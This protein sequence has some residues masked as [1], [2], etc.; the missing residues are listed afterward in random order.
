MPRRSSRGVL[1]PASDSGPDPC[2][3]LPRTAFHKLFDSS[4]PPFPH[5]GI[6]NST[7]LKGSCENVIEKGCIY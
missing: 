6:K 5:L 1:G 3:H 7:D 4:E 2:C